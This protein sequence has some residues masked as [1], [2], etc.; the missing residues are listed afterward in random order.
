MKC[1]VLAEKYYGRKDGSM[2][3]QSGTENIVFETFDS[4]KALTRNTV[5]T[6]AKW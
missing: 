3:Q 5:N 1:G 4:F 2:T 6:V